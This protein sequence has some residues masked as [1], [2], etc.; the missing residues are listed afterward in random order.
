MLLSQA[1]ALIQTTAHLAFCCLFIFPAF[2]CPPARWTPCYLQ[3]WRLMRPDWPTD[4]RRP[5]EGSWK[6]DNSNVTVVIGR[7]FG[8]TRSFFPRNSFTFWWDICRVQKETPNRAQ[9]DKISERLA[10]LGS[11]LL[12][13]W[14]DDRAVARGGAQNVFY[15]VFIF[16]PFFAAALLS[17]DLEKPSRRKSAG[18]CGLVS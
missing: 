10:C 7:L 9:L 6:G 3:F 2:V 18:G 16:W 17:R 12:E 5:S 14:R 8:I 4:R 13:F 11:A 1:S 15:L